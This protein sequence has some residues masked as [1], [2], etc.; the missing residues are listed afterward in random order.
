M[1]DSEVKEFEDDELDSSI[2]INN[3]MR[4]AAKSFE[5]PEVQ[6]AKVMEILPT[7]DDGQMEQLC[8]MVQALIK[9]E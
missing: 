2:Y 8:K 4:A 6:K 5:D 3:F 7:L 1:V 9:K